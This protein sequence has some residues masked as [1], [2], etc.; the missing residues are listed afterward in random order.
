MPHLLCHLRYAPVVVCIFEGARKRPVLGIVF[1]R[2]IKRHITQFL[3]EA[4]ASVPVQV[5]RVHAGFESL[6]CI[7][8]PDAFQICVHNNRHCMVAYHHVGLAAPEI[9][10]RQP[11]VLLIECDEGLHHVVHP[12]RLRVSEQR[13]RRPEG[14]PQRECPVVGPSF[15]LVDFLVRP[16]I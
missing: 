12:C 8:V 13:M 16:V 3:V 11:S 5:G 4:D 9:P 15:G 10:Y 1:V 6:F 7:K 14:V 2:D